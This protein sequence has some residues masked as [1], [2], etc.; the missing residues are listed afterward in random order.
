MRIK[1]ESRREGRGPLEAVVSI[2]TARGQTE[3]VIVHRGYL[4]EGGS[5]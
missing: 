3:E 2:P 5:R 4:A 1:F